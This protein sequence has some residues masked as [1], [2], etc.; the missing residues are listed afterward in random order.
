MKKIVGIGASEGVAVAK[1]LKIEDKELEITNNF[2]DVNKEKELLE[3]SINETIEQ[4]ETI[5]ESAKKNIGEAEAQVFDAHIQI[6][7]DPMMKGEIVTLIEGNNSALYASDN[8]F[9][10]Y[11]DMF[12]NM[13]DDYMKERAADIHDVKTRVVNNIAGVGNVDLSSIS[14]E[15]IVVADDITPSETAQM[16][17]KY[18]KGFA[19]N[20]GGKTSHAAI[21]ARS[22]GIPA[23]LG[24][25]TITENVKNSDQIAINGT[26]GDVVINPSPADLKEFE[27]ATNEMKIIKEESMKFRG[28]ESVSADG[29]HVELV[30]NIGSVKD[31]QILIEH[32]S[33]GVG[34]FRSE[35][36]Y[37]NSSNWPTEE[38]QYEAYKSV[39]EIMDG[40]LVVVRT[41]DIGGDKTLKYF[42]FE[43]ELN[44]FLGNRAIRFCLKNPKIFKTQLR[45][46]AR[47]SVHGKLAIM[48]PM[49]AIIDEFVEAKKLFEEAI[50]E[51]KSEGHE[52]AKEIQL[53]MMV[54]IPATAAI[55]KQFAKHADFFSIGTND[56][57]QYTMAS[58]RMNENVSYLYQPLNPAILN[59]IKMTIDGAHSENK[60]V[61][62]CGEMAGDPNAIP[63]LLGLGLDEF[64]MSSSA[65][66]Q[67]RR[68]ISKLSYNDM[69]DLANKALSLSTEAEVKEL[70]ESKLK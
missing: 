19:S 53:G 56:L 33:E 39:L 70:L 67:A 12:K 32:D 5:K 63:L 24:L 20:V 49:I 4:L 10:K 30:A 54:E 60:W 29:H 2:S 27:K 45:A 7:L 42:K 55:A 62:M 35:F 36:L 21:M 41:L 22:M 59:L 34:L 37:M 40:K 44:P 8:V 58:D 14:E 51:V 52:V 3:K 50:K 46:L 16:N 25:N 17:K 23:V 57:M 61:G 6:V 18:V 38:E 65:I 1:V 13:D 64:S 69:K 15:V 11:S 43:E 31:A 28:K 48:F 9:N 66:L 68:Q 47:A 26:T